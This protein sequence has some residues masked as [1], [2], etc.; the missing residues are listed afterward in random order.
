MFNIACGDS[1]SVNE[2]YRLICKAL[3]SDAK[4]THRGERFG[5]V[6]NSKANIAQAMKLLGYNPTITFNEG[7]QKT[8]EYYTL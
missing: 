3:G 6:K 8:I 4:A 1:I 2:M 5:D 7:L